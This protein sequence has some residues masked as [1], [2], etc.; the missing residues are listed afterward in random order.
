MAAESTSAIHRNQVDLQEHIDW[1]GVE[2]LN[3]S[4]SHSIVNA[5][6]Q[7]HFR[8]ARYNHLREALGGA[9]VGSFC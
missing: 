1:S 2:C 6:K 3:Q 5:L 7:A 8:K 4:G 9:F